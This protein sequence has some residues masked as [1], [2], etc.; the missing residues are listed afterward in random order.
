MRT[1]L[2]LAL[3]AVLPAC[4]D[5]GG[6]TDGE[7]TDVVAA[8]QRP[9]AEAG[10]A[11]TQSADSAVALSGAASTDPDGDALTFHWSFDHVPEGSSIAT[12]EAPFTLNHTLEASSTTFS[13][14]ATGTYVVQ[15]IVTDTNGA[16]SDPDFVIVTIEDPET[17]PVANAGL[18]ITANV[19]SLV[20]LDGSLSYDPT[21]RPLTYAWTI[22]DK[23]EGSTVS[24]IDGAD[25]VAGTFTPDTKGVYVLNLVVN[26]GLARSVSDAVTVTA[27]ADDNA[28]VANAGS[29]QPLAE[30]CSTI[31]L[32]CSMSADPDGDPLTYSWDVQSKPEGSAVTV[33]TFSDRSS[34]RPTF[35]PD[36][37]GEYV[38]SCAVNDGTTWSTPD[39]VTLTAGDRRS[40][41][42]PTVSAG[43]DTTV[44]GGSSTCEE[45]GYTYDCDDCAT[46][47]VTLTATATDAD[48]DPMTY[49]WSTSNADATISSS[50]TLVTTV[51]L[52][53]ATA[54][55]P[56]E[57]EETE[58]EFEFAATDCTGATV[59]DSITIS[60]SCCGVEDTAP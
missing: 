28:P 37:A 2:F 45:S 51:T 16:D 58:Y 11:I 21:G 43:T 44:D 40:N 26:N 20:T 49:A 30:D 27:I 8:N 46:A 12:R 34:A 32:D 10:E 23:P 50:N 39:L 4:T 9:I 33:A 24:G 6:K 48:G 54:T 42:R 13:P 53:D 1:T 5:S 3:F 17:V 22:L 7:D 57:C 52:E 59:T 31:S 47:T 56:G 14:D 36:I 25:T 41:E 60:V 29:D 18:D 15:L 38:L 19:A 35:Y 55:E